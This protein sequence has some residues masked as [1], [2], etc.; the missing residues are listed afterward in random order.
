MHGSAFSMNDTQGPI[1][2]DNKIGSK[3]YHIVR[4]LYQIA[5]YLSE[6]GF[7]VLRYDKRGVGPNATI[8]NSNVWGNLAFNDLK[9]DAEKALSVLLQQPEVDAKKATIIGHSEST[10]I[11][12]R[13]AFDNPDKVGNIVLMGAS[14]SKSC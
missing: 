7:A 1:W 3:I 13:I 8:L 6:R 2:V 11:A 5:E 12:P 10:S 4:P 9:Q 14:S